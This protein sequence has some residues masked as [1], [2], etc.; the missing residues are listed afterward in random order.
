M[1]VMSHRCEVMT[2][3]CFRMSVRRCTN[4][5]YARKLGIAIYKMGLKVK[6]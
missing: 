4:L 6:S 1:A 5:W 3:C 2:R